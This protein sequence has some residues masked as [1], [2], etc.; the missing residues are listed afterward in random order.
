MCGRYYVLDKNIEELKRIIDEA[1]QNLDKANAENPEKAKP[2]KMGEVFPTDIVPVVCANSKGEIVA[3][4]MKWGYTS[5]DGK[6]VLINARSET[7]FDKAMFRSGIMEHRCLV[8]ALNYYEWEKKGSEKTKYAIKAENEQITFLAG[9]FRME[10]TSKLPVFVILTK[11]PEDNIAFIHNRMPVIIPRE[12][13]KE[14]LSR[15]GNPERMLMQA[16]Q[17]VVFEAAE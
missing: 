17:Q 9:I 4:P 13:Q 6:G 1:Q 7:V 15:T 14:W 8:P 11:N 16:S 12:L 5:P 2:M 3:Y 10:K